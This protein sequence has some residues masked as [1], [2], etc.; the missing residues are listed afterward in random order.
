MNLSFRNKVLLS[1]GCVGF[2][3]TTLSVILSIR[4]VQHY[5]EQQLIDKSKAVLSRIHVGAKYVAEM[6]TLDMKIKETKAKFPDGNI[7]DHQ[8]L[9]ILK[10]VPIYAAFQIGKEGA[11]KEHYQFRVYADKPRNDKNSPTAD[12]REVL[13]LFRKDPTKEFDVRFNSDE[14]A[15]MVSVPSHINEDHGCLSCHGHPSTSPWGNGK[16][17]LGFPMENMKHGDLKGVMTIISSMA[18]VQA[19]SKKA[20]MELTVFGIIGT[21]VSMVIGFLLIKNPLKQ[22]D[23]VTSDV[24]QSSR[25]VNQASTQLAAASQQLASSSQQQASS[26]QEVSSSLEEISSMLNTTLRGSKESVEKSREV[27]QLV[28]SGSE[29][30]EALKAAVN[31]IA[32]SNEKVEEL[33]KLIEEI[34]E[35]TELIDEI[36]FQTKLL[37]FNAS[38]EAERAGE[39]GRGF[40]VV[41]Q[42]VGNL[43]QMSGRSAS[44]IGDIVK[45]SVKEAQEVA[46]SNRTKVDQGVEYCEKTAAQLIQ[47]QKA[48]KEILDGSEKILRASEE[49]NAGVDQINQS[50]QLINQSTQENASAAEEISASGQ[51]LIHQGHKLDGVVDQLTHVMQG[52]V[53]KPS[54][55]DDHR[56]NT[57]GKSGGRENVVS[58]QQGKTRSN[59]S[60]ANFRP[61]NESPKSNKV[62]VGQDSDPWEKL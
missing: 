27:S 31:E 16:D 28:S 33:V 44:E 24:Q 22:L 59:K 45:Q 38:V 46:R 13:E 25:D 5:G 42:E 4:E 1:L 15:I 2:I 6:G 48:S 7:D 39:H 9:E 21:L 60:E 50:I 34:G 52:Q 26:V 37:S 11:E 20:A 12:E 43:A 17:I 10:S 32:K 23:V 58:F 30:M 19:E 54:S 55:S 35:K 56:P 29:S 61:G 51:S 3:C 47:I 53:G 36:V 62:A 57:D 41:A 8:R 40:A 18:P 49:Q 14:S